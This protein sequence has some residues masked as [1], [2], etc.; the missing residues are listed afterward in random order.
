MAKIL[1]VDDSRIMRINLK[2][3]FEELGHSVVAEA[4]DGN[5]ALEAYEKHMPDLVTMDITMPGMSG[6]ETV[7]EMIKR[8]P[9]AKIIMVS[10]HGQK[11]M[12]VE[13]ISKGAMH[14]IL[15][16]IKHEMIADMVGRFI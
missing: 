9:D 12:V 10:S 13:A 7:E 4:G 8:F 16:P 5:S 3:I 14:Y 6:I 2:K 15:K 11:E 1:I